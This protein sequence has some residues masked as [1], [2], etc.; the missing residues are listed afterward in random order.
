ME[1]ETLGD[2]IQKIGEMIREEVPKSIGGPIG[3]GYIILAK[4]ATAASPAIVTMLLGEVRGVNKLTDIFKFRTLIDNL[5]FRN[6]FAYSA[7]LPFVPV[8]RFAYDS[9]FR[10]KCYAIGLAG[11]ISYGA[12]KNHDA[13]IDALHGRQPAAIEKSVTAPQPSSNLENYVK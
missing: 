2:R 11:L 13:I 6:M 1:K 12:Y 4:T 8:A 10:H 3:D 9:K 5:T 7:G